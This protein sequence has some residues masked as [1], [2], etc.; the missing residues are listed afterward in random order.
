MMPRRGGPV[1]RGHGAGRGAIPP[2]PAG[3]PWA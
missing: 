3:R 1:A 2:R